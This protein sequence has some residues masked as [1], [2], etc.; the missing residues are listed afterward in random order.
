[1]FKCTCKA[2]YTLPI[3]LELDR[4]ENHG[5]LQFF[6]KDE[7]I[8]S[9]VRSSHEFTDDQRELISEEAKFFKMTWPYGDSILVGTIEDVYIDYEYIDIQTTI[10]FQGSPGYFVPTIPIGVLTPEWSHIT[11]LESTY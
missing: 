6:D 8:I 5:T 3:K 4:E 11:V 2:T 10:I 1:M 7:K 9:E